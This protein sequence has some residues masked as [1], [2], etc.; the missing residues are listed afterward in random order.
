ME[1]WGT[2]A[3][4][5]ILV[6]TSQI[7]EGQIS[8]GLGYIKCYSSN[9]PRPVKSHSNST[10]Y[11]YQ[12]IYRRYAR[13]ETILEIRK[14]ATFLLLINNPIIYKFF[15]DFTNHRKKTNK[16]VGFSYTPFPIIFEYR[17]HRWDFP[18][19]WKTRLLYTF[20]TVQLKCLKIQVNCSLELPLE[21]SYD[22]TPLTN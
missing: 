5:D 1:F 6:K 22:Q 15:K 13:P 4:I 2:R 19:I 12:K 8:E 11:N 3:L 20:W 10:K 18:T 16:A 9:S 7:Y 17:N 21:Y 14:K